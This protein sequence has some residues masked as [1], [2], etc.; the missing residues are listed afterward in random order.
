MADSPLTK[1]RL[2]KLLLYLNSDRDRAGELYEIL[3]LK[4]L[5]YFK[6]RSLAFAEE[7]T[8]KTLDR[9]IRKIEEGEEILDVNRYCIGLAR[10]IWRE[11]QRNPE[12]LDISS[13]ELT[14]NSVT[15]SESLLRKERKAF[16]YHCL[17]ELERD[18]RELIVEY[19]HYEN[20]SHQEARRVIAMRR[21]ISLTALRVR[22][23]RIRKK[24]K[25]CYADCLE[26]GLPK[27][28]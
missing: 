22:V 10:W 1:E 13:V 18:D 9:L 7:L 5:Q 26:K 11:F 24:L 23:T 21:K 28:K 14:D 2:D 19:S 12:A 16:Y 17:Q 15:P 20:M 27:S 3:R 25:A 8:D 6:R 4:L